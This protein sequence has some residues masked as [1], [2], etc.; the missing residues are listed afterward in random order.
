MAMIGL[1]LALAVTSFGYRHCIQTHASEA[2]KQGCAREPVRFF[3]RNQ[4]SN[5]LAR[6]M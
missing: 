1:L 2:V 6:Q 3:D 4:Y 5:C